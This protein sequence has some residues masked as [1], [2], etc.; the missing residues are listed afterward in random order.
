M[1]MDAAPTHWIITR[2]ELERGMLLSKEVSLLAKLA[3][4]VH[5]TDIESL[6][7]LARYI[8]NVKSLSD[9]SIAENRASFLDLIKTV[10]AKMNGDMQKYF[11]VISEKDGQAGGVA[12]SNAP[13]KK[14]MLT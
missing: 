2:L 10:I 1:A 8:N 9:K 13:D 4:R 5:C 14:G 3:A 7:N 12:N 6:N 11:R